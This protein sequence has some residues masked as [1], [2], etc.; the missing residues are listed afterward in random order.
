MVVQAREGQ[1]F[2][3][4]KYFSCFHILITTRIDRIRHYLSKYAD[5]KVLQLFKQI[6]LNYNLCHHNLISIQMIIIAQSKIGT[7]K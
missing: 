1:Q 7:E 4:Q 6:I 3:L 5:Y 2:H